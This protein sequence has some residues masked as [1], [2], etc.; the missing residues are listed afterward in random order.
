MGKFLHFLSL[1]Q[2]KLTAIERQQQIMW[3]RHT[4]SSLML[5]YRKEKPQAIDL[6]SI[7]CQQE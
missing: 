2:L 5:F 1:N 6:E 7:L 3:T 4:T